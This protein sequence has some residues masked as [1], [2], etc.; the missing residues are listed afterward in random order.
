MTALIFAS[1]LG[2]TAPDSLYSFREDYSFHFKPANL[3][4]QGR[5]LEP[6]LTID[7]KTGKITAADSA[8]ATEAGRVFI[9]YLRKNYQ[10]CEAK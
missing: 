8:T 5:G 10:P 2:F 4:I 3:V 1:L 7:G 9:E 6:L